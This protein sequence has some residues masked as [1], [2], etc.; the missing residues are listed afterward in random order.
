MRL[1]VRVRHIPDTTPDNIHQDNNNL[2]HEVTTQIAWALFGFSGANTFRRRSLP[3]ISSS[4]KLGKLIAILNNGLLPNPFGEANTFE[5]LHTTIYIASFRN[6][7]LI[8]FRK[9][10]EKYNTTVIE[11]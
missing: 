2:Y 5:S 6:Y 4:N 8:I 9:A 1:A 7:N 3:K 10:T 11:K